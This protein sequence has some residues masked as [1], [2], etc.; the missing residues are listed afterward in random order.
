MNWID[1]VARAGVTFR[2][3]ANGPEGLVQGKKVFAV[4]SRGGRYRGTAADTQVPYLTAFFGLIGSTDIT[5]IYAEGLNMGPDA[6]R[7]GLASA[8]AQ[9]DEALA[10]CAAVAA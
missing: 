9:M 2:Y 4:L 8:R 6:E 3:T 5:F 1:A 10:G 7:D